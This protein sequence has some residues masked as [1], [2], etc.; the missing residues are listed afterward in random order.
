MLGWL[1]NDNSN[2]RMVPSYCGVYKVGLLQDS[3]HE[4]Q[5]L[6][7]PKKVIQQPGH[8]PDPI[9]TTKTQPSATLTPWMLVWPK[10]LDDYQEDHREYC[11]LCSFSGDHWHSLGSTKLRMQY[12]RCCCTSW[13][14]HI[15]ET[16]V[17]WTWEILHY[18]RTGAGFLPSTVELKGAVILRLWLFIEAPQLQHFVYKTSKLQRFKACYIWINLFMFHCFTHHTI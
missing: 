2:I 8:S 17:R 3:H 13:D 5:D 1:V 12:W 15:N 16:S 4:L 18:I 6:S 9:T 10:A 7:D 11:H 14:L